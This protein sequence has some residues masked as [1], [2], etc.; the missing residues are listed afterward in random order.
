[1]S[2][3]LDQ[4]DILKNADTGVLTL[5][6][7][8]KILTRTFCDSTGNYNKIE[9]TVDSETNI[10]RFIDEVKLPDFNAIINMFF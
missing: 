5:I 9:P 10:I 2:H 7:L 3:I 8:L 1:M 6:D 4:M